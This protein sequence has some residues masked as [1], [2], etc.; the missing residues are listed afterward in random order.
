M[1]SQQWSDGE[2]AQICRHL[3]GGETFGQVAAACEVSTETLRKRIARYRARVAPRRGHETCPVQDIPR[4]PTPSET[5]LGVAEIA[6]L[7]PRVKSGQSDKPDPRK[8]P[9]AHLPIA[10]K[11]YHLRGVSSLVG[12]DGEMKQ[13]WVKTVKDQA[14]QRLELVRELLATLPDSFR[15]AHTPKLGPEHSDSDLLCVY[16]IGDPHFGM[17]AWREECGESYDLEIA[18]ALHVAAIRRLVDVAP[19]AKRA[20]IINLGDFFHCDNGQ[21]KTERSGNAL[22]TD[23]RWALV[24]RVGFRAMRAMIDAALAKH[25][26]VRVICEIGNHDD[27]SAIMLAM[28]LEAFYERDRRVTIDTSPE[29]YHWHRFGQCLLGVTHGGAC[30]VAALPGIMAADKPADWGQTR[31]RYWYTGH[32]HHE[33]VQEFPGCVCESFRTLAPRDAWAHRSG[34]RADRDMRCDVLHRE[35]GRVTRHILGVEQVA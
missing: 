31:H 3:D 28:G 29:P 18:E 19:P 7:A 6:P 34:Y 21:S 4:A 8:D 16:P 2:L 20:L 32:V 33:S 35:H 26:Q 1:S 22:D 10:P 13:Q 15:T 11:G 17:Y 12:P 25:E 24:Q 27:R 23:T 9:T 30:K 14:T 5:K